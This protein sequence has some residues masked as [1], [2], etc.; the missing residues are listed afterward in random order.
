MNNDKMSNKI[1]EGNTRQALKESFLK[2]LQ[3]YFKNTS[4][5]QVIE[6][7]EGVRSLMDG[8]GITVEQYFEMRDL[9]IKSEKGNKNYLSFKLL[10]PK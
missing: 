1:S 8:E 7:W 4:K 3:E 10:I 5:E 9:L 6:D 2:E